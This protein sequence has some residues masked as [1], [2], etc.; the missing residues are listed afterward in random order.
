VNDNPAAFEMTIVW[1]RKTIRVVTEK[2]HNVH[3]EYWMYIT[4][5]PLPKKSMFLLESVISSGS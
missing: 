2:S 3:V 4:P 5:I 1:G